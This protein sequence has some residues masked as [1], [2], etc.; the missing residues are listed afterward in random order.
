ME[1]SKA[2]KIASKIRE[3]RSIEIILNDDDF[4]SINDIIN[5][6]YDIKR[7]KIELSSIYNN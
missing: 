4:L 1:N 5:L 6:K 2:F 7:L 3:I